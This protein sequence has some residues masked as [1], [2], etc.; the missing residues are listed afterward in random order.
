L[1]KNLLL[2]PLRES[3]VRFVSSRATRAAEPVDEL[4]VERGAGMASVH[5]QHDATRVFAERRY[6]PPSSRHCMRSDCGT[7]A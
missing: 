7:R 1:A 3:F 2:A 6:A 5:E 4:H